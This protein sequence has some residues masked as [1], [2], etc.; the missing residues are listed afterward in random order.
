MVI[1]AGIRTRDPQITNLTLYLFA[2]RVV[3][4][5]L[6]NKQLSINGKKCK[7]ESKW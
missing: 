5:Q 7:N 2:T 1:F 6:K 3:G 4:H